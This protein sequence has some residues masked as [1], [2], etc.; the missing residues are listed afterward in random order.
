MCAELLQYKS[1]GTLWASGHTCTTLNAL[2]RIC[3]NQPII[4]SEGPC[5]TYGNTSPTMDTLVLIS[6]N[7]HLKENYLNPPPLK[8]LL[9]LPTLLGQNL[10]NYFPAYS[11]YAGPLDVYQSRGL[12]DH[13]SYQ[14]F[15]NYSRSD[16]E[17]E[18]QAIASR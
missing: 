11:V 4:K 7:R 14:G 16:V 8:C 18:L 2:A 17:H 5:G 12:Q 9:Y 10:Q 6:D 13:R 3:H 15:A 1:Q